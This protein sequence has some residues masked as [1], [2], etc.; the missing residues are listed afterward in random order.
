MWRCTT[1]GY[2][3]IPNSTRKP[4]HRKRKASQSPSYLP[5]LTWITSEEGKQ[6]EQQ[7][8]QDAS[9]RKAS[10]PAPTQT[11]NQAPAEAIPSEAKV[12]DCTPQIRT[13]S[14]GE[15]PEDALDVTHKPVAVADKAQ[16]SATDEVPQALT[17]LTAAPVEAASYRY[18]RLA[19]GIA[20]RWLMLI[21]F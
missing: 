3:R 14:T 21:S 19:F 7:R 5:L 2:H 9:R 18:V 16:A 8:S 4:P 12:G 11:T 20:S 1:L 10:A 17:S 15:A 13:R 6:R